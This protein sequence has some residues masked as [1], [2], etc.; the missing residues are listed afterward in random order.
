MI[1]GVGFIWETLTLMTRVGRAKQEKEKQIRILD[2]WEANRWHSVPRRWMHRAN[3]AIISSSWSRFAVFS[4]N[5]MSKWNMQ[6]F[7]KMFFTDNVGSSRNWESWV[8]SMERDAHL[9]LSHVRAG[10]TLFVFNKWPAQKC[11]L[12]KYYLACCCS[13]RANK[14]TIFT[15]VGLPH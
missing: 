8:L 15:T 5:G 13:T 1:A 7:I 4:L 6:F 14:W 9:L 2:V 3:K 11:H 10:P 12:G